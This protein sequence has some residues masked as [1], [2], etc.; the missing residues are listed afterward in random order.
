M[1]SRPP[2]RYE[3]NFTKGR[4]ERVSTRRVNAERRDAFFGASQAER[5]AIHERVAA[6]KSGAMEARWKLGR[7]YLERHADVD[8]EIPFERAVARLDLP[9]E[10][11]AAREEALQLAVGRDSQIDNRAL[12]FAVLARDF[13]AD[14]ATLQLATSPVLLAPVVRYFGALP[15]LFNAFVTR[16]HTTEFLPGTAHLFHVDPEDVLTHKVF[17]HLTDVD[18]DGGPLHVLPADL[19]QRV[20]EAVDYRGIARISDGQVSDLVGWDAVESFAVP[21]G[22]VA[23]ADTS[24]CL[25]FGG[26]PRGPGRPVRYHLVFQYLL[27]TSFV[28]PIDG[29][30]EPPRFLENLEPTGEDHWDALLGARFT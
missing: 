22:T 24:R 11:Q 2:M 13:A 26:R 28:F 6:L 25:H 14:S 16:A 10:T 17:V 8:F 1:S 4:P 23:F 7:E 3:N 29:D 5:K 12:E 9:G 19:T 18:D 21:A 27:P 15:V 30:C 20:L